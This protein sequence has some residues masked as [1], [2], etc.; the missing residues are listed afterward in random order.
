MAAMVLLTVLV[1]I[2]MVVGRIAA[3]RR[4]AV[5]AKFYKTHQ[6]D[7]G[8]PHEVAQQTRHFTNLFESPVLFYA[9]C[10]AAMVTGQGDGAIVWLAWAYVTCRV[11][12]A[13][14]HLGANKIRPRM[15]IYGLSWIALLAIWGTVVVRV[16]TLP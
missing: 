5:D 4:G 3:V 13:F 14:I 1:L 12:H 8:E 10:I 2:R 9:G 16:T 11:V 7:E 15:A 6:G